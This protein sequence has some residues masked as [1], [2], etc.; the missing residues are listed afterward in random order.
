MEMSVDDKVGM[1]SM[2]YSAKRMRML[3][4]FA[5]PV[6]ALVCSAA[7]HLHFQDIVQLRLQIAPKSRL[8]PETNAPNLEGQRK[9]A[10]YAAEVGDNPVA[11]VEQPLSRYSRYMVRLHLA[12][13]DDQV[14][15]INA[16]PGGLEVEVRDMTGDNVWNDLVV[17]PALFQWPLSVLLN[18]GHDHFTVAFAPSPNSLDS[19]DEAS[20]GRRHHDLAVLAPCNSKAGDLASSGK[21]PLPKL[22]QNFLSPTTPWVTDRIS[23]TS[24]SGR[25]PPAV[26]TSI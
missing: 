19:G 6:L 2:E 10:L 12:A 20:G 11:V 18:D 22:Q 7:A 3:L 1:G 16:P 4:M 23:S 8:A 24:S 9:V 14:V 5:G 26:A 13:G 17:R 21:I 25:A 15:A